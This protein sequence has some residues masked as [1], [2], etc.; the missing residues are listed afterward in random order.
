MKIVAVLL[1][2][3]MTMTI[4]A[5]PIHFNKSLKEDVQKGLK[6]LTI[7]KGKREYY[8]LGKTTAE[9]TDG[10][11]LSIKL[12]KVEFKKYLWDNK[13]ITTEHL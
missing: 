5:K 10:T 11:K 1:I 4:E 2:G 9:F 13:N 12:S 7:R 6:T 3:M 8:K